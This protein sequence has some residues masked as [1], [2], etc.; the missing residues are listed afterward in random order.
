M[1]RNLNPL[2]LATL[3]V[4]LMGCVSLDKQ[5]DEAFSEDQSLW[6]SQMQE[7]LHQD[8]P[9]DRRHWARYM[10]AKKNAS[11]EYQIQAVYKYFDSIKQRGGDRLSPADNQ[12]FFIYADYVSEST[13][14]SVRREFASLCSHFTRQ[15]LCEAY[16]EETK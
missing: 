11:M 4:V 16:K 6:E 12:L 7:L 10:D 14:A 9:V 2:T 5:L 15:D 1:M 3:L 13:S 8:E